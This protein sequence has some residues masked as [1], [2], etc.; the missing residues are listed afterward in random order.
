MVL[1]V[2]SAI[3]FTPIGQ[4]MYGINTDFTPVEI[5]VIFTLNIS[6]AAAALVV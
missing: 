5:C 3:R 2:P 4:S 1:L 6:P